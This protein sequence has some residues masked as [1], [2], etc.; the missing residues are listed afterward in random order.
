MWIRV[1]YVKEQ[2][3]AIVTVARLGV[4]V[5]RFEDVQFVIESQRFD[6]EPGHVGE[7]SNG[8]QIL[9]LIHIRS[10]Q[11]TQGVESRG[12]MKGFPFH[13]FL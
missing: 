5:K 12:E 13:Y 2:V 6:R 10:I 8:E 9:W 11:S 4:D 3:N 1:L 7:A